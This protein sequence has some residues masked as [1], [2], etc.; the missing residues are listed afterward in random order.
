MENNHTPKDFIGTNLMYDNATVFTIRKDGHCQPLVDIRGWG[1][2][3]NLFKDK[4][5]AIDFEEANHFQDEVG[6][7]IRT[8]IANYQALKAEN[9]LLKEVNEAQVFTIEKYQKENESLTTQLA[10]ANS[11]KEKLGELLKELLQKAIEANQSAQDSFNVFGEDIFEEE[12]KTTAA[13]CEKIHLVL[14]DC[15]ITL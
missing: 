15:G 7:I 2:I 14:T 8:S 11:D 12:E 10:K 1:A 3:Q 9:T 5:G 13:L 4:S 6:E